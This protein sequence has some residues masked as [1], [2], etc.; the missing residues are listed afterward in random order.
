VNVDD[1]DHPVLKHTSMQREHIICFSDY[2]EI[3][4]KIVDVRES[5]LLLK[6]H[7]PKTIALHFWKTITLGLI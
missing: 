1:S 5:H 6:L 2:S 4:Q 7:N 3:P